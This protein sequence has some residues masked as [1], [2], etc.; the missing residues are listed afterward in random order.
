M[1]DFDDQNSLKEYP[2]ILGRYE[3][4]ENESSHGLMKIWNA[5]KTGEFYFYFYKAWLICRQWNHDFTNLYK[6]K[7]LV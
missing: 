1:I 6:T 2:R 4:T 3:E 5:R 7:T